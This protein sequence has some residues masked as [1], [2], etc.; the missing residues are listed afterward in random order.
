MLFIKNNHNHNQMFTIPLPYQMGQ[1][2]VVPQIA[3]RQ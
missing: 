1:S 2:K 3:H